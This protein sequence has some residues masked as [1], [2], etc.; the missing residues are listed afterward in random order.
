MIAVVVVAG[1]MLFAAAALALVRVE[2]GPSMLDRTIAF[3]VLTATLVGVVALEAAWHGRTD[4]LPILVVLSMVGFVGSVTIA[5]FAAVEPEDE[6][7]IKTREEA[8]AEDEA[9]QLAE[10]AEERAV[11][12]VAVLDGQNLLG[13][14]P[15]PADAT[16]AARADGGPTTARDDEP[17]PGGTVPGAPTAPDDAGSPTATS[18]DDGGAR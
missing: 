8:A 4:T 10:E 2:K 14:A 11:E 6:R 15:G 12:R 1:A 5:R 17:A 3:D 13:R 7:R 16:E 18:D 9:R